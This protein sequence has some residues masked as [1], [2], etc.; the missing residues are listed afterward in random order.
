ML[1][2]TR[3]LGEVI[4][5]PDL[6]VKIQITGI[7]ANGSVRVGIE[8]PKSVSIVRAELISRKAVRS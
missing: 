1:C 3:R 4:V 8:A 6:N 5:L 7:N 2:V